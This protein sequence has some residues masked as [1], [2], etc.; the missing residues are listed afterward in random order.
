VDSLAQVMVGTAV[1]Q[2]A[3]DKKQL[4]PM[5]KDVQ[6]QMGTPPQ[7]AT[8]DNG[9]SSEP[10]VKDAQLQGSDLFVAPH[11]QKHGEKR[12]ATMGDSAFRR[13]RDR[14]DAAQTAD[15]GRPVGL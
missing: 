8:A 1:T 10:N 11:R 15:G 7:Q 4:V 12:P 6:V 3:D 9:Y 5:V 13:Q 2:A 14:A